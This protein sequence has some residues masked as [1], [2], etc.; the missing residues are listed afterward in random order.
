MRLAQRRYEDPRRYMSAKW[1]WGTWHDKRFETDERVIS[2]SSLL[3][4]ARS[5]QEA[6]THS[7]LLTAQF[8]VLEWATVRYFM[9]QPIRTQWKSDG[10]HRYVRQDI[11]DSAQTAATRTMLLIARVSDI[12]NSC[13][14]GVLVN[15]ALALAKKHMTWTKGSHE[16]WDEKRLSW[17][18]I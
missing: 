4:I 10:Q 18:W 5:A 2:M 8:C 16:S 13:C 12:T 11:R 6:A 9:T 15:K 3:S 17:L 7:M 1:E 14:K